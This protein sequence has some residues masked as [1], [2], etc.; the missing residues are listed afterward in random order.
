MRSSLNG[1]ELLL[2]LHFFIRPN[3]LA[4]LAANICRRNMPELLS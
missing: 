1:A 2:H 4:A 3:K